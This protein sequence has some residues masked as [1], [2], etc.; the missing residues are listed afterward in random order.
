M[1]EYIKKKDKL[2]LVG[3]GYEWH[4][5]PEASE[6]A[7]IWGINDVIMRRTNFDLLF[8]IHK[9]EDYCEMDM[10][11]TRLASSVG[12]PVM[13]PEEY[14]ELPTSIKFPLKEIMKEFDT[15]Y[16]MTGIAFMFAYAAYL[17]Y[18]QIDCYGINMRGADEK[19]KNARACVEYWIGRAQGKGCKV[20]MY[21]KY[22]DCLKT[23]DR[24]IYGFNDFQTYPQDINDRALYV[25]FGA[26]FDRTIVDKMH[27]LLS[28]Q[29]NSK[30]FNN[31]RAIPLNDPGDMILFQNLFDMTKTHGD[32]TK[33]VGDIGFYN[34]THVD[35]LI[36]NEHSAKII[37]LEGNRDKTIEDWL[38]FSK[39]VNPWTNPQSKYWDKEKYKTSEVCAYFSNKY[40]L[41]KEDAL[42]KFYDD[43]YMVAKRAQF[44]YPGYIRNW[45]ADIL[46][47][48]DGKK[49]M[50]KFIG[51]TDEEMVLEMPE[52]AK[53]VPPPL[54]AQTMGA[55]AN[56]QY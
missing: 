6:D 54:L 46:D 11:C 37:V 12:I 32:G 9:L 19:Y 4:K 31:L 48:D 15:D 45:N 23:F 22:C 55:E 24:R 39:D 16:L 14:P 44:K 38:N 52:K 28:V 50:L 17:G 1:R 8:N 42:Q 40:D 33:F 25:S 26:S 5:A 47:S 35:K 29:P 41:P 13:M 34:V 7:E 36:N 51:Y 21:G 18:K 53:P 20:N 3:K 49:A 30:Y 10:A 43:Y 27:K 56:Y 2:I